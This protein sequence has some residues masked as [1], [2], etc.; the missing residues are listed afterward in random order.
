MTTKPFNL[1]D[2]ESKAMSNGR[3]GVIVR[4]VEPQP[5]AEANVMECSV[6][7]KH[8]TLW[9]A[10]IE[11]KYPDKGI[12]HSQRSVS[13]L[14]VHQSWQPPFG[15]PG[16]TL[17]FR[18]EW[19]TETTEGVSSV[20]FYRAEY[21]DDGDLPPP[22]GV[23]WR[24]A[25]AMPSEFIRFRATVG[26]VRCK[27]V[28]DLEENEI[29]QIVPTERGAGAIE[30]Q[31]VYLMTTNSGYARGLIGARLAMK[32][33]FNSIHGPG[34]WESNPWLWLCEIEPKTK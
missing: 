31:T 3:L 23:K 20:P 6:I 30:G 22:S 9:W 11:T 7:T 2:H 10:G 18:E 27:R 26:E 5:P 15:P 17:E 33:L 21:R 25:S 13:N 16:T 24:P 4:P 32:N 19:D 29:A 8:K 34:S 12:I 28:Q 14:N 1:L